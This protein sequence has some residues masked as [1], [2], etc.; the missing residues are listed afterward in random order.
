MVYEH[1]CSYLLLDKSKKLSFLLRIQLQIPKFN[2][3]QAKSKLLVQVM[4]KTSK[5]QIQKGNVQFG[6]M[7]DIKISLP[8]YSGSGPNLSSRVLW[9]KANVT[10][11]TT[12]VNSERGTATGQVDKP[13]GPF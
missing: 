8:E 6:L 3:S 5:S 1:T 12:S 9:L 13:C 10:L 4:A 2:N 7:S 11:L